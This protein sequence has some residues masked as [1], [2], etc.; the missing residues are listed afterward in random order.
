MALRAPS[1]F[2]RYERDTKPAMQV[3]VVNKRYQPTR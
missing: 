2:G 3:L 1:Q